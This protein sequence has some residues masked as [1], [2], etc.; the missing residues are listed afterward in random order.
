MNPNIEENGLLRKGVYPLR[1]YEA[2]MVRQNDRPELQQPLT[3]GENDV[4]YL[5]QIGG[6]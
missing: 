6:D 2:R 5:P 1:G 3:L 4:T